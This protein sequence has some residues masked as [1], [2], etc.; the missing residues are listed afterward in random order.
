MDALQIEVGHEDLRR[1][2]NKIKLAILTTHPIQY[3][4]PWFRALA[5]RPEID[6]EV[7]YC[8]RTTPAEQAAAGFGVEFEWDV[9]ILDGYPHGFLENISATPTVTRFGGLDTPEVGEII[10]RKKYDAMVVNGWHYKSAW[11]TMRACWRTRT[12]VM[13]RSDSHLGTERSFTR[14]AA[15]WPLYSWF[16]PKLDACLPVGRWSHDYF[17]HYGARPERIFTVPHAVDEDYFRSEAARWLPKRFELRS[18]WGI[19]RDTTVFL[20]AGKFIAKKRPLDFV[21]AVEQAARQGARLSGLMV[22]DGP[23]RYECETLVRARGAPIKFAG[24]LNQ[25]EIAK[26]Y[27]AAD[28]LVLPSDGN[29]T[30]GL[31]VNEAMWCGRPC[32]V[33]DKVGCGPDLI[34][35]GQTGEIFPMGDVKTL[36]SL[37]I[38]YHNCPSELTMMGAKAKKQMAEFSVRVAV[39]R[40]LVAIQRTVNGKG[41]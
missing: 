2:R 1:G 26:A 27:V 33:T 40:L 31:V 21:G 12:P 9:P 11:Q 19:D 28:A 41:K 3:H 38:R 17:L 23:L 8:H 39:D 20:F 35:P 6:L 7:I 34:A 36:A 4:A 18:Q 37:V 24:F 30:W 25:S 10:E 16:I 29:E 13:V 15:K 22:G 32:L 14:R 5:S